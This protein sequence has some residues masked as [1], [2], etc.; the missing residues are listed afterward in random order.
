[1]RDKGLQEPKAP[2]K[3]RKPKQSNLEAYIEALNLSMNVNR[4]DYE[5]N[6]YSNGSEVSYN[7]VLS[8]RVGAMPAER[9][10]HTRR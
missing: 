1:M 8:N 7:S 6:Y 3:D 5:N 4:P 2:R 9:E 10:Y